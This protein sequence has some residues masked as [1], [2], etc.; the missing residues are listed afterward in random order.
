MVWM[1]AVLLCVSVAGALALPLLKS[2]S[3]SQN[4]DHIDRTL[5]SVLDQIEDDRKSGLIGSDDAADAIIEAKREFLTASQTSAHQDRTSRRLR[6]SGIIF[7]ALM[8]LMTGAIYFFVKGAAP[9]EPSIAPA[10]SGGA[11]ADIAALAPD[12]R[13]AMIE[14]MVTS[15]AVRLETTPEDVEG[16]R[17]LARSY[18]VLNQPTDAIGA[19]E[20]L[21][22]QA[23]GTREDLRTYAELLLAVHGVAGDAEGKFLKTLETT[24]QRF[25]GDP[26]ALFHL[27]TFHRENGNNEQAVVLWR[28]LAAS[29]P[30]DAPIAPA[31]ERLI[32]EAQNADK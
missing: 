17:M 14:G 11:P 6:F 18:Q 31:L 20:G 2:T 27:G 1:I 19:F 28:E 16:W 29:L 12:E 26:V 32:A 3:V 30:E 21:F 5:T 13:R 24:L 23:K 15:L 4:P 25:P 10:A 22:A 8:P 7:L 9:H